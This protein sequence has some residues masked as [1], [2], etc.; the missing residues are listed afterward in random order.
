M[1]LFKSKPKQGLSELIKGCL[2]QERRAQREFY[3]RYKPRLTGLCLR[4]AK[5]AVE[6]E[7]IFQEGILK[8]F[9]KLGEVRDPEALDS[10]VKTV[11]IRHAVDY[12][13]RVTRKE[14]LFSSHEHL[15]AEWQTADYSELLSRFETDAI[16]ESINDLPTGYRLVV[17]MYFIDGYSHAEIAEMLGIAEVTS[18]SQLLRG[19]NVLIKKLEQKGIK[20]HESL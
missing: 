3:E 4:Y 12:Y 15:N 11:M 1:G 5:T 2:K 17:N 13:N 16:L 18:R 14:I 19:R 6:A 8:I 20:Q 10:W 7:D 9:G